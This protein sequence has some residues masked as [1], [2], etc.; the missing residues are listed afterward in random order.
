MKEI[1]TER[2][3]I[4]H[5][6]IAEVYGVEKVVTV[7]ND[8]KYDVFAQC[9]VILSTVRKLLDE[10][11]LIVSKVQHSSE[12][13]DDVWEHDDSG[14]RVW[15]N[16]VELDGNELDIGDASDFYSDE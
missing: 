13:R 16:P 9:G 8:I 3:E 14:Y 5:E 4:V 12:I 15:L 1:N 11:G 2:I 7:G 10:H 6:I